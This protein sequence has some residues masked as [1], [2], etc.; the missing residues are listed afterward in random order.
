MPPFEAFADAGS[1]YAT[2]AHESTHWTKQPIASAR[3]FGRKKWETKA[4]PKRTRCRAWRGLPVRQL[5]IVL[6]SS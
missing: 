6:N 5:G 3:E 1:Y 4:M 2:V